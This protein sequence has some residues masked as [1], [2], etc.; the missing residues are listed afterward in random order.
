M[1]PRM[2]PFLKNI[3]TKKE[4]GPNDLGES[5]YEEDEGDAVDDRNA[6]DE[7]NPVDD[8]SL[9]EISSIS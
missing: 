1:P 9:S 8:G 6:A 7:G 3:D 2:G 5:D 4:K